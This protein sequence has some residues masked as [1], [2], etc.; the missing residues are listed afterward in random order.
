MS[1]LQ[2]ELVGTVIS[3]QRFSKRLTL[4]LMSF[5]QP[6]AYEDQVPDSPNAKTNQ[7]RLKQ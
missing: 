3:I 6:S 4:L 7:K 2:F 1:L 5:R